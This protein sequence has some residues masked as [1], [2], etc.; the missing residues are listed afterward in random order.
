M[1]HSLPIPNTSF[2]TKKSCETQL[3][4]FVDDIQRN[5]TGNKQ[6]DVI[7]IDFAKA[8][9]KVEHNSLSHKLEHYGIRGDCN[10]WIKNYLSKPTQIVDVN[11]KDSE[12]KQLHLGSLKGQS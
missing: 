11:G 6:T 5:M 9:D 2:R 1:L 4:G 10:R 12:G 8:S 3:L 7:I